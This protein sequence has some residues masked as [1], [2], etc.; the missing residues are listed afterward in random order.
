MVETADRLKKIFTRYGRLLNIGLCV[1]ALSL[2]GSCG[3]GGGGSSD[4]SNDSAAP[5]Q[6]VPNP[7]PTT[8]PPPAAPFGLTVRPSFTIPN[9]PT[10]SFNSSLGSYELVDAFPGTTFFAPV[11][12]SSVPGS[13]LLIVVQQSGEL[14]QLNPADGSTNVILDLSS[15]VLFAGEQGLLG[16]ALDPSFATNRYL[17]VHYSMAGPRRS[18]ISRF[19]WP[20]SGGV[21]ISSE[22]I[23]LEVDQPFSNHNGGMLAFGPD[24]Y[25]YIG[26]GDGGAGGDPNNNAQTPSNLLGSM[27]RIDVRV[28]DDSTPYAVPPDNPFVGISDFRPETYAFG[29]RN[30]F[31]FSFDRAT[32]ELWLGDVGQGALE[33][34]DIITAG[35]NYGWRVFEGTNDFDSSLSTVTVDDVI[36][37]V[38]E[39]GRGEGVS[40]IGGYVYRGT[41]LPGLQGRYL[42]T[43]FGSGNVWALARASD[44]SVTNDRIAVASNPTSFGQDDEGELYL[45]SISGAVSR[46]SE[47]V[48]VISDNPT[49]LSET[50]LF[51]NLTNLT[52]VGGL[53]EYDVNERFWSDGLVKRRWFGIP[54]GSAITF[55]ATGNWQFPIGTVTVKHFAKPDDGAFVETRV[56]VRRSD[57]WEGFTYAWN[58]NQ[59]DAELVTG[60]VVTSISVNGADQTYTLP[61]PSDCLRCHTEVSGSV[62]GIETRQLNGDFVYAAATD[63]QLRSLNNAGFF[64]A[65]LGSTENLPAF[66]ASTSTVVTIEERARTYLEVNCAQCH[67][68]GGPTPVALDLRFDTP[69]SATGLLDAA[70]ADNLGLPNAQIIQPRDRNQSVLFLRMQTLG[71]Q[72]M[73]PISSHVVDQA[74]LSLIGDWIDTL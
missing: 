49:L 33:E 30:P 26:F 43:D 2:L 8:Q 54:D 27:L 38:F 6:P 5:Q 16:L 25:L 69:L 51:S 21:D 37:P 47:T 61:G 50:G 57:G 59:S 34:I 48:G 40:V 44:G 7:P 52:P 62:L 20:Q 12:L 15:R 23:I 14:V 24:D 66:S 63:N 42:Y 9:L 29:F 10:N 4:G 22:K 31:R 67:Q 39:Y 19:T 1:F 45:L 18:V 32:G 73:P 53:I 64:T 74:G 36:F 41:A 46:L 55:S 35:G 28:S 3:G 71:Q 70:Q 68:P 60:R 72:R 65:D 17:Y 13:D 11:F 58:P 56:F